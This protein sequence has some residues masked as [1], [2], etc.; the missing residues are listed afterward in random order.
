MSKTGEPIRP[1]IKIKNVVGKK[2]SIVKHWLFLL[3]IL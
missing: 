2:M 1:N 3:V